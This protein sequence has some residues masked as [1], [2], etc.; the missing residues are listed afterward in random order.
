MRN[1]LIGLILFKLTFP[2]SYLV[3]FIIVSLLGY[4]PVL[5]ARWLFGDLGASIVGGFVTWVSILGVG[6][7]FG[8]K[9]RDQGALWSQVI[10][11]GLI[12]FI[13]LPNSIH[14]LLYGTRYEPLTALG[15]IFGLF[16]ALAAALGHSY[17]RRSSPRLVEVGLADY[18]S[19]A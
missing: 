10:P 12:G 7:L 13:C 14:A 5:A 4:A 17:T 9:V 1:F 19:A 3:F 15:Q 6:W 8:N 18:P 16:F 2:Y 11:F